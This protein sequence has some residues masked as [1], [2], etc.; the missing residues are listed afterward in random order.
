MKSNVNDIYIVASTFYSELSDQLIEGAILANSIDNIN[1]VKVPGAFEI[2]GMI[3][4][5]IDNKKPDLII[6]FGVLIKG[7][8]DHFEYISS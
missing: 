8:S 6:A 2:P 1:V 4:N 3:K 5:L 7:E